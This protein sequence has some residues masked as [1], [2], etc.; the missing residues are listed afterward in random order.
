[1]FQKGPTN[2]CLQSNWQA[3]I[4]VRRIDVNKE[5]DD[6]MRYRSRLVNKDFSNYNDPDLYMATL[7]LES[8]PLVISVAANRT[9]K[10]A[11]QM[12]IILS[13]CHS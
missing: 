4:G 13:E 7:A 2:R 10:S 12:Q 6:D 9:S 1:M 8:L 3:P 5:G 11:K